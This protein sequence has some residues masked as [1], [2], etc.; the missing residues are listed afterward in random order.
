MFVYG[1]LI[2]M[3]VFGELIPFVVWATVLISEEM[4]LARMARANC[5]LALELAAGAEEPSIDVREA[6]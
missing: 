6:A 5:M 1:I 2:E 4:L 3:R